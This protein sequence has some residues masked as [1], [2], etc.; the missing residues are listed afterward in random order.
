VDEVLGR[1]AGEAGTLS[2]QELLVEALWMIDG[3]WGSIGAGV[4]RGDG[5]A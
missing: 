1:R 5:I 4:S 3:G 2:A